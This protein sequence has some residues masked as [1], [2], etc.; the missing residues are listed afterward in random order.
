MWLQVSSI[1]EQL[2]HTVWFKK[3]IIWECETLPF[4]SV[5]TAHKAHKKKKG[6]CKTLWV[7]AD[8]ST[9]NS[10]KKYEALTFV[11]L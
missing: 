7:T 2:R 5:D 9:K 3:I 6:S 4:T 1:L 10:D 11:F 8:Y